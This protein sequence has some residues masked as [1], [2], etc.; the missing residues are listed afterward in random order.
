MV[1]LCWQAVV[2]QDDWLENVLEVLVR[3]LI[4][5]IDATMLKGKKQDLDG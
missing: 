1:E 4:S 5:C 2:L 3:V